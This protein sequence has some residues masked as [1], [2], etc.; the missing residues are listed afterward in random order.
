MTDNRDVTSLTA[1]IVA[2]YLG[3]NTISVG[4]VPS[5][6]NSVYSA[7]TN[8]NRPQTAG[9]DAEK[10]APAVPIKKSVRPDHI[11]CLECGKKNKMLK[12]HLASEH[13]LTPVE[14]R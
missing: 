14:Y 2:A 12:R 7:I 6:I 10:Q 1:Q 11:V 3:N 9:E 5:I 4:E 8:L 13:G